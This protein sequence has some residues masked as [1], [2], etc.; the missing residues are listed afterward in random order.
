M[1]DQVIRRRAIVHG[2]VQGVF[3]RDTLRRLAQAR[4]V[5]GS[6]VNRPDGAVEAVFEG[7]PD[8]VEALLDFCRV[9]PSGARVDRVDASEEPPEG[10][11]GF[12]IG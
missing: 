5:A 12:R 1:S 2:V 7:S 11:R 3:F 6:A 4:N 9:G 10:E 8:A